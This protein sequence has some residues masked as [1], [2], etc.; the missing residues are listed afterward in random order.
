MGIGR[1]W[2]GVLVLAVAG[3]ALWGV[4]PARADD[5]GPGDRDIKRE[6]QERLDA[7]FED[8]LF[9]V[10][11]ADSSATEPQQAAGEEPA[12]VLVRYHAEIRFQRDYALTSLE[13][14][15]VGT[16]IE[17]LG[18]TPRDVSGVNAEGN[19]RGDMLRVE[20]SLE[21]APEGNRWRA[22]FSHRR[23][24][25]PA[26][27]DGAAS[28]EPL[29]VRIHRRLAELGEAIEGAEFD[30][31]DERFG[32]ELDQLVADVECRLASQA[33]LVRLATGS[34]TTEYHAL[35]VGLA[36]LMN[37]DGERL[38]PRATTGSVAN[39]MLLRDGLVD[40]AL[41]QSDV[42]HL[43]YH[44]QGQFQGKLPMNEM[45][46]LCS[47]F[48]EAVHVVTMEGSG[49]STVADL[50]GQSVDVGPDDS[51]TRFNAAQVLAL[52][53]LALTDLDRVQGKPPGEALDD[54]IA[55]RVKAAFLTGVYPYPQISGRARE[56]P[57]RLVP[58]TERDVEAAAHVAPFL[59]PMV[60][61]T[62]TYAG[63]EEPVQT[64][65]VSA[66]VVARGDLPDD[67]IGDLLDTLMTTQQALSRHTLQAY[68]I[69]ADTAERGLSIPLHPTAYRKLEELRGP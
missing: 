68:F 23:I 19:H 3:A 65:G 53:G 39:V 1:W 7:W 59:V 44:G 8:G 61:P 16:L 31:P 54:L 55:G 34:P 69:S 66:L 33:G 63:Q 40:V 18:S 37:T 56:L 41:V 9:R 62:G 60:I 58:L 38:H 46:A 57:L 17:L 51:G 15:N 5:G 11:R 47:L 12:S 36:E 64:M 50:R 35:G 49:I 4:A 30:D 29:D 26:A 14:R 43:A 13:S 25:A 32:I 22:N 6:L 24:D 21:F 67:V 48:P 2:R 45:R 20:G 52:N 42:A 28:G 10:R 27:T